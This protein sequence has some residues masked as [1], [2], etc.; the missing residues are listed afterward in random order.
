MIARKNQYNTNSSLMKGS[1][2][3][4][5]II[6]CA[7]HH[8]A[9]VQAF[10]TPRC[11]PSSPLLSNKRS[12]PKCHQPF[13]LPMGGSSTTSRLKLHASITVPNFEAYPEDKE[14]KQ[15]LLDKSY[16]FQIPSAT[17]NLIKAIVGSGVL[18]LPG[19][20]AVMSNSPNT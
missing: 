7:L 8:F 1:I 6:C 15:T 13:W 3:K 20:L 14:K 9:C 12:S 5:F 16:K 17:F 10:C 11:K 2:V 4:A 18:A 19:G